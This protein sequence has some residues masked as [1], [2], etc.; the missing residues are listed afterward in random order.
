MITDKS[1]NK[2]TTERLNIN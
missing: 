1:Q 2:P